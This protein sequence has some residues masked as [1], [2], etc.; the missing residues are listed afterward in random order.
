MAN[1]KEFEKIANLVPINSQKIDWDGFKGTL[2]SPILTRMEKTHQNPEYHGEIDVLSHTK[3]VCEALVKQPEY[4]CAGP[5]DK[6][7]LFL[8]AL[9]HDIGKI[10]C[11]VKRI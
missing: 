11:T 6:T 9:L 8:A 2:L 3:M 1:Y 7:I 5:K 10:K 4:I